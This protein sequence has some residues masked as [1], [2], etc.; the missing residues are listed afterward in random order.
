MIDFGSGLIG[1][2]TLFSL[3]LFGATMLFGWHAIRTNF[4]MTTYTIS[5]RA[6]A[7]LTRAYAELQGLCYRVDSLE[8]QLTRITERVDKCEQENQRLA[9]A[10]RDCSKEG[11]A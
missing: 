2:N 6:T 5:A 7:D 3:G 4:D 11:T 8:Q 1:W 9:A 10:I